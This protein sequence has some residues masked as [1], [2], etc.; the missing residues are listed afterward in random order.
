MVARQRTLATQ[1]FRKEEQ[2]NK[3]LIGINLDHH[4]IDSKKLIEKGLLK[5]NEVEDWVDNYADNNSIFYQRFNKSQIN[6]LLKVWTKEELIHLFNEAKNPWFR[7]ALS[8]IKFD[9]DFIKRRSF[10][11]LYAFDEVEKCKLPINFDVPYLTKSET[12]ELF[13]RVNRFDIWDK[14]DMPVYAVHDY[15][16][17]IYKGCNSKQAW[18]WVASM[19]KKHYARNLSAIQY[20]DVHKRFYLKVF[21]DFGLDYHSVNYIF[22]RDMK[23]PAEL[24][25]FNHITYVRETL[26][27]SIAFGIELNSDEMKKVRKSIQD[28]PDVPKLI[29]EKNLISFGVTKQQLIQKFPE[30]FTK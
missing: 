15:A 17:A 1:N 10:P 11:E 6:G 18:I 25:F 20:A 16:E 5:V 28:E 13:N 22:K 19:L 9:E 23:L 8:P 12:I 30:F 3:I 21:K 29:M 27:F 24:Y 26:S 14:L 7:Y 2:M 4:L